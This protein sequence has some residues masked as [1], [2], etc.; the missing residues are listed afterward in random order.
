MEIASTLEYGVPF[1]L[2]VGQLMAPKKKTWNGER[3]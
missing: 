2:Y 1:V 3:I